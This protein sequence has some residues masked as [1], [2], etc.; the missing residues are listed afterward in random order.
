MAR[1]RTIKPEFWTSEQ[2]M[3]CSPTSRLL[4]IGMWN[5]CDDYGNHV[6]SART[7]KAEVFPGDDI[8]ISDI[9]SCVDQ[10]IENGLLVGYTADG[11]EYWH[12][13]GWRHQKIEKPNQKHPKFAD[14][15]PTNRGTFDEHSPPEGNGME[16]NGSDIS[17]SKELE[18]ASGAADNPAKPRKPDCPH[19]KIIDL[20][21]EILPV[22]PV[23]KVWNE[24]RSANLRARWNE[25]TKRQSLEYWRKLFEY[26]ASCDF[27]VGRTKTPFFA[28]LAWIVKAE[29]FAKIIE[30]NYTNREAA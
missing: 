4:F 8:P 24:S 5:F 16:G 25:D 18:V 11:K 15:S 1:I 23:V 29:N 7:L 27:L 13:T 30:A 3:E 21:H 2:V 22:N 28:N 14:Q 12:V 6:A 19:Q 26:I 9:Q 20:Y 17:N 10:L